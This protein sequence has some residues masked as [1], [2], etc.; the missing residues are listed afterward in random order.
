MGLW[1][2]NLNLPVVSKREWKYEEEEYLRDSR[3]GFLYHYNRAIPSCFPTNVFPFLAGLTSIPKHN[4]DIWIP[5]TN[6]QGW[7]LKSGKCS[8]YN[9]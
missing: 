4:D 1:D 6:T 3:E 7:S 2:S 8:Q 5:K 9:R